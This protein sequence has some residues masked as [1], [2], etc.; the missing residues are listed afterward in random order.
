ME[1]EEREWEGVC[2][3]KY[4]SIERERRTGKKGGAARFE[5]KQDSK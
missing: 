2:R 5:S 3:R 1:R 4:E